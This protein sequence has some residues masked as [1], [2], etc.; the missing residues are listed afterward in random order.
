MKHLQLTKH[1]KFIL[2]VKQIK[3]NKTE[4]YNITNKNI[5]DIVILK[6]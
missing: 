3:R 1:I 6:I 2:D 5:K 4:Y